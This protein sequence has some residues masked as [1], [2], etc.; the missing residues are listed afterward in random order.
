MFSISKK[1]LLLLK[2]DEIK[3]EAIEILS[4]FKDNIKKDVYV[5][6]ENAFK[7]DIIISIYATMDISAWIRITQSTVAAETFFQYFKKSTLF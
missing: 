7:N 2:S 5:S 1:N 6:L 3:A 4:V